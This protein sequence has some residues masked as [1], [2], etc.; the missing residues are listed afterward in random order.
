MMNKSWFNLLPVSVLAA[1]VCGAGAFG[2]EIRQIELAQLSD[3][4]KVVVLSQVVKVVKISAEADEVTINIGAV[5]KGKLGTGELKVVLT[6]RGVKG[7]DPALKAGD[8]GVFLLKEVDKKK[9]KLA[10]S[11]SVAVF[12]KPNFIVSERSYEPMADSVMVKLETSK[13]DIVLE[14]NKKAASVTVDNFITYVKDGF[15]DGTIFHR[16]IPNFMVQGGGFTPEMVQ[17]KT[18]PAIVNEA[19]NGL[20]N[21]RG[22]IAMARTNN[23]DSAT[24]QFFI[25]HKDNTPLD[26]ASKSKPGYAVFGKVVE[27]MDVVDAIAAVKTTRKGRLSDVPAEPVMIKSAKVMSE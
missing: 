18:N 16:V 15:Y 4:A 10:Y 23:P 7:F 27:G 13:G 24:S 11:G 26:Y 20:K 6:T 8:T 17:K 19:D 12:S 25:N 2:S 1:L 3:S 9:A 21:D 5:L 22:T 14:L